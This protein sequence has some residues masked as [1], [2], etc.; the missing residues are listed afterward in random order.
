MHTNDKKKLLEL[1]TALFKKV[2]KLAKKNDLSWN[3][4]VRQELKKVVN[5]LK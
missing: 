3:S 2:A 5:D 4:F 1:P